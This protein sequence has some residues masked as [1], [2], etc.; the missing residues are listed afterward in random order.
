MRAPEWC[1]FREYPLVLEVR[2]A[3]WAEP[4]TFEFLADLDISL[5]NIDQ[6]LFGKSIKPGVEVTSSI[7]YVRLHGRNYKT[8]F[9]ESASVR[10]RYDYLYPV[11][12]LD[13]WVDRTIEISRKANDTYVMS[14]NHNLGKAAVNALQIASLLKSEPVPAPPTLVAHYPE[15]EGFATVVAPGQALT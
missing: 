1:G 14:N 9:A 4:G 7:G 2:H 8:W 15:L 5:C 13:P 6:P 3:S 11:D 12:E 10:E